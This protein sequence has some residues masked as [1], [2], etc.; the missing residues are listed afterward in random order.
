MNLL[1]MTM[2]IQVNKDIY[3]RIQKIA[4]YD[5]VTFDG[6]LKGMVESEEERIEEYESNYPY[7]CL[8]CMIPMNKKVDYCED[9][10]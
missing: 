6:A 8:K 7:N 2:K 1:C 4:E 5:G 10:K 9:C 3:N